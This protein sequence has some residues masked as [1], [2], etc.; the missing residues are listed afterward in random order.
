MALAGF[1][2]LSLPAHAQTFTLTG[3]VASNG[4]GIVDIPIV[5]TGAKADTTT[6]GRTTPSSTKS[7]ATRTDAASR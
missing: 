4:E 3:A 7:C 1:V 5:L 2:L 6:T